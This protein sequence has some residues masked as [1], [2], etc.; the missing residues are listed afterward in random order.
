M[1]SLF[2]RG[3]RDALSPVMGV[4]ADLADR[5]V[6]DESATE[7]A[8]AIHEMR[9]FLKFV[10]RLAAATRVRRS[11]SAA[12]RSG[13]WSIVG[14]GVRLAGI[15]APELRDVVVGRSN[16]ASRSRHRL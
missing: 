3:S 9:A 7:D 2:W 6:T 10:K 4:E 13:H 11:M 5:Q 16:T 14:L 12:A 15:N 8:E 1:E